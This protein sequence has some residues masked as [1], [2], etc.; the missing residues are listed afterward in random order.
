MTSTLT[1]SEILADE[2][3]FQQACS[4]WVS[5]YIG[6][7]VSSL[8]HDMGQNL[9]E[10]SRIFDF[11]YDEAMG[12]FQQEDWKEP[13]L[14]FINGAGLEDLE[15]IADMVGYWDDMLDECGVPDTYTLTD[16]DSEERY[17]YVGCEAYIYDDEGEAI[18]AARMSVI[19]RIR[20]NVKA[21]IWRDDDYRKIAD[22]FGLDPHTWEIYEHW[23][24]EEGYVARLLQQYEQVVFNFGGMRI[25]ARGTT[26]QSIS[27]DYV[28]RQIVRELDESHWIWEEV[29]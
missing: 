9:E 7:C 21:N 14:D 24:I 4:A 1:K 10:C 13:V 23:I 29:R 22:D 12:W 17:G 18:Q 5:R 8:M 3:R 6:L 20:E 19:D 2:G 26:G 28:I 25:W 15:T 16:E 11:D 27:M